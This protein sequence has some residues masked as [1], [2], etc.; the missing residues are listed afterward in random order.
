MLYTKVCTNSKTTNQQQ[1]IDILGF[2]NKNRH[3]RQLYQ[4][5]Y[6]LQL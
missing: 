4:N 6:V 5:A 1:N 3:L 2:V